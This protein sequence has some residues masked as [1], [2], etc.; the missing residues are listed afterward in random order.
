MILIDAPHHTDLGFADEQGKILLLDD[1]DP[2]LAG[3]RAPA[4][5]T[6]IVGPPPNFR[7]FLLP[8][9]N[10]DLLAFLPSIPHERIVN[11]AVRVRSFAHKALYR[12][13]G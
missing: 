12:I 11:V 4:P 7:I 13:Y 6:E 5:P 9:R 8:A 10:L 1:P 2:L 3:N